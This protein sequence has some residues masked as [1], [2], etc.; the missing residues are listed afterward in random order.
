M[1]PNPA[2]SV[3]CREC[4]QLSV[5]ITQLEKRIETLQD[6]SANEEFIDS[7]IAPVQ[8]VKPSC[9]KGLTQIF[10]CWITANNR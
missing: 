1:S 4:E 2:L 3:S 10:L 8:A 6:I 5:R 9:A 7:I